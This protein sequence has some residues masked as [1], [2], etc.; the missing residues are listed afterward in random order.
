MKGVVCARNDMWVQ[1]KGA[2]FVLAA[3]QACRSTNRH[4]TLS[5]KP[6]QPPLIPQLTTH[7][8]PPQHPISKKTQATLLTWKLLQMLMGRFSRSVHCSAPTNAAS[9]G[10][11][12]F[13]TSGCVTAAAIHSSLLQLMPRA[14]R[15]RGRMRSV[16]CSIAPSSTRMLSTSCCYLLFVIE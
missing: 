14:T 15:P 11:V 12:R 2:I 10:G 5:P 6:P 4:Q 13:M 8:L 7:L 3:G 16:S 1:K 9:C